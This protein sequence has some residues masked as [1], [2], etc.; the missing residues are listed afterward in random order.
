MPGTYFD[1]DD[2]NIAISKEHVEKMAK[3]GSES[4]YVFMVGIENK[5]GYS[6]RIGQDEFKGSYYLELRGKDTTAEVSITKRQF[7]ELQS[8]Y[9][10]LSAIKKDAPSHVKTYSNY[11]KDESQ[12][13]LVGL[14]DKLFNLLSPAIELE[15]TDGA[16][17]AVRYNTPDKP[18]RLKMERLELIAKSLP[19]V[20]NGVLTA[21][22]KTTPNENAGARKL[23]R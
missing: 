7:Q 12:S 13:V 1:F 20:Q 8:D 6:F 21:D 11:V 10:K 17:S 16:V 22:V 9:E 3:G 2:V 5:S 14:Q 4:P 19:T 18:N 15:M 23:K